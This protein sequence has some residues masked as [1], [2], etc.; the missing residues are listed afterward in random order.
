MVTSMIG[1]VKVVDI[2]TA[3]IYSPRTL[4][5]KTRKRSIET[6]CRMITSTEGRFRK[7]LALSPLDKR[8]DIETSLFE[9]VKTP[10][11][12][13]ILNLRKINGVLNKQRRSIN[14]NLRGFEDCVTFL[15]LG[16]RKGKEPPL[17]DV[18]SLIHLQCATNLDLVSI[19]DLSRLSRKEEYEYYL[20][21]HRK[22]VEIISSKE[23]V[24]IIDMNNQENVFK[25]KIETAIENGFKMIA[26]RC[27]SFY[28][29][30][31]NYDYIKD[32]KKEKEIWFHMVDTYRD[33]PTGS[34]NYTNLPQVFGIDTVSPLTPY[35]GG[36]TG[37]LAPEETK[38]FDRLSFDNLRLRVQ[39]EKYED[40]L[41][42]NCPVCQEKTVSDYI[43]NYKT[44]KNVKEENP[45]YKWSRL[46]EVFAANSEFEI[47]R[48]L[49][50]SQEFEGYLRSKS[51]A[52]SFLSGLTR[53]S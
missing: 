48:K 22:E 21:H 5:I 52:Q 1:E 44:C 6:P 3:G 18:D 26:L 41:R 38:R 29:Y 13:S 42:C 53:T 16:F 36:K 32:T 2:D 49:I 11:L 23:A 14:S 45:I 9:L 31:A 20:R 8:F 27:R 30:Y 10:K 46:H 51:S 40:Q 7:G 12:E 39:K 43:E 47:G 37:N 19:P 35:G 25:A 17:R 34:L 50:R 24:P 15:N 33:S 28:N 4:R